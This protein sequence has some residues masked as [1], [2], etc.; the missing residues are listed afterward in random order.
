MYNRI[1]LKLSGELMMGN[2]DFGID[3]DAVAKYASQI[4][5]LV[6]MGKQIIVEIGAGNI[7]RGKEEKGMK[8]TIAD[9]LGMLGSVMNAINLR[10]AIDKFGHQEARALS[11]I[12]MPYIIQYYTPGKAIHY[13]DEK[14]IVIMGGGTGNQFFS[15]D[16]GAVLHALQTNCDVVL[17]A[18]NVDGVY[19]SDPNINK[20][21]KK[22]DELSYDEVLAKKLAVMDQTAFALARDNGLTIIVF[23]VTKEGNLMKVINGEKIGTIIK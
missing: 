17:K 8:R 11:Q 4:V 12:Y 6:K 7:Y 15:T 16:T 13:M 14:K 18:T 21:A 5:E 1:M 3:Q 10:E 20:N 19:D 22:Y 2:K 9:N 23:N